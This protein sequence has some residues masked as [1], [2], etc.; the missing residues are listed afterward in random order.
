MAM[1][2]ANIP[3]TF[4][5][6]LSFCMTVAT[7]GLVYIAYR[8]TSVSIEI[9]DAKINLS[10][11]YGQVQDI[12]ANLE[13]ENERLIKANA[14]LQGRLNRVKAEIAKLSKNAKTNTSL[15]S[16]LK[17][18]TITKPAA[19]IKPIDPKVFESLSLKLKQVESAIKQK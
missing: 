10:S 13:V 18:Y 9:A 8:S 11:A 3:K 6:A 16:V 15:K 12:K 7:L 4:W 19:V 1:D 5:Y 2:T 14:E 17:E